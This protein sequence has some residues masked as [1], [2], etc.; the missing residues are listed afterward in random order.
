MKKRII[1]SIALLSIVF[2]I[3]MY[4]RV[5]KANFLKDLLISD[6]EALADDELDP[7]I[8]I[9]DDGIY[10]RCMVPIW[11]EN[12]MNYRCEWYCAWSGK[13]EDYCSWYWITF[14]NWCDYDWDG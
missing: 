14:L 12:P 2:S 4:I 8:L 3:G 11:G 9:C 1:Y 7:A 6:V 5:E 13:G 10:G